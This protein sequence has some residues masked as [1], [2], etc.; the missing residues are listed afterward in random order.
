MDLVDFLRAR[1]DEDEAAIPEEGD[2]DEL[3]KWV[4]LVT[5]GTER[6]VLHLERFDRTRLLREV[7][8]KR[9]ILKEYEDC[10]KLVEFSRPN[11]PDDIKHVGVG[12]QIAAAAIEIGRAHV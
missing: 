4:E 7:G 10:V 9:R 12:T 3:L 6:A 1:L 11:V 2:A 8:A 5:P